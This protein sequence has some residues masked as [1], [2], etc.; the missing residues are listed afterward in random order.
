MALH[1]LHTRS[2]KTRQQKDGTVE[3]ER[4]MRPFL[5]DSEYVK[6]KHLAIDARL[7]IHEWVA[8]AIR[9]ST[10]QSTKEQH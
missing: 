6:V 10:K 3:T 9:L 1:L 8:R 2:V 7:T 4:F 5:T